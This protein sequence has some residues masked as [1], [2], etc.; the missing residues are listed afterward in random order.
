MELRQ[1]QCLVACAQTKSFSNAAAALFTSQSNVSKMISSLE[2]ELGRKLFVRKQY[3]IELTEKG[4]QIYKFAL[5]MQECREKILTCAKEDDAEELRVS[6]QSSSWFATA[7]CDYYIQNEGTRRKYQMTSATID[8]IV[9]R[10][11]N[12]L[13][14]LGFA[15]IEK[16]QLSKMKDMFQSNHIGYYVLKKTRMMLYRGVKSDSDVSEE[17][18]LLLIQGNDDAYSGLSLWK[19]RT[20]TLQDLKRKK[21]QKDEVEQPKSKVVISTNSDYIMREILQ[22]TSLCNISPEYLSHNEKSICPDSY[23]IDENETSILFICMFRNDRTIE[24]LPK[25][26]LTYVREYLREK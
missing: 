16:E 21:D 7:F 13:D 2:N 1:L 25:H 9:R 18:D 14:Q 24:T 22:R 20:T 23:E 3:G 19:E 5:S 6:F 15:Y 26:F 4:R 12:D 10:L 8:E 11:Y 17:K